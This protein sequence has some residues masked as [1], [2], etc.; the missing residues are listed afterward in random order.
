MLHV[1]R[2]CNYNHVIIHYTVLFALTHVNAAKSVGR[3][4][5]WLFLAENDTR[6]S[7][8]PIVGV[9]VRSWPLSRFNDL[10]RDLKAFSTHASVMSLP[11]QRRRRLHVT[12]PLPLL[13]CSVMASFSWLL[14]LILAAEGLVY[15]ASDNGKILAKPAVVPFMGEEGNIL[16]RVGGNFSHWPRIVI[17]DERGI[18]LQ[19]GGSTGAHVDRYGH[20]W[21][22]I[23]LDLGPLPYGA[24]SVRVLLEEAGAWEL[25]VKV[26]RA[27]RKSDA[28]L[29]DNVKG[30]MVGRNGLP[31]FPFGSYIYGVTTAAE[32]AVPETEVKYGQ[33][34][35]S[36]VVPLFHAAI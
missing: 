7:N 15:C 25:K 14:A 18:T 34:T 36:R 28:V 17:L 4:W 3:V 13:I 22:H 11:W 2:T 33:W 24:S 21:L 19:R 6:N 1:R 9:M 26:V 16:V 31:F 8:L 27:V 35:L 10:V 23:P 12:Q 5:S 32:R 29:V 20:R 30:C